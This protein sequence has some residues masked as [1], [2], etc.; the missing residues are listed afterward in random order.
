LH[1]LPPSKTFG[2]GAASLHLLGS[3]GAMATRIAPL[4]LCMVAALAAFP[5]IS[6]AQLSTGRSGFSTER[7]A[8]AREYWNALRFFGRCFASTQRPAAFEFLAT[9]PGSAQEVAIYRRLFESRDVD[10]IG[11]MSRMTVIIKFVRGAIAE[12]MLGLGTPVPPQLQIAPPPPGAPVA[13]LSDLARCYVVGHRAAARGLIDNSRPGSDEEL[14]ALTQMQSDIFQC[15]P[16]AARN[17][18]LNPTDVRFHLAE[19]LLRMPAP[20]P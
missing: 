13:T 10:C 18:R 17:V 3:E 5:A 11:E 16:P 4:R 15:L 8:T 9:E 12:G 20:T 19:A 14:A 1:S 7:S 6:N 2:I